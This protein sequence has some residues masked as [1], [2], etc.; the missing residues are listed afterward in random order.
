MEVKIFWVILGPD[1]FISD[2]MDMNLY[3][4]SHNPMIHMYSKFNDD[5]FVLFWLSWKCCQPIH[6][7][8]WRADLEATFDVI[9]DVKTMNNN[10]F[11]IIW[12]DHLFIPEVKL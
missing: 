5:M 6:K 11:G 2:T 8:I 9:D 12:D 1:D 4:F 10:I 3:K 7:G